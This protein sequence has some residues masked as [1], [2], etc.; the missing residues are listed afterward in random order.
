MRVP[1]SLHARAAVGLLAL[2]AA[3]AA[4]VALP[5]IM[6]D[7]DSSSGPSAE[8][9]RAPAYPEIVVAQ[10]PFGGKL[11][12][13]AFP[14]PQAVAGVPVAVPAS[15]SGA[16]LIADRPSATGPGRP[17]GPSSPVSPT[18]APPS[19]AP[20][21]APAPA[22]TPPSAP[23][24]APS[25]P[26]SPSPSPPPTAPPPASPSP[27]PAPPSTPTPA[28]APVPAPAPA[29]VDPTPP[30]A[31]ESTLAD[32]PHNDVNPGA[33]P[34]PPRPDPTEAPGDPPTD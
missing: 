26:P 8:G 5:A 17:E 31:S 2:G 10:G 1:A 12:L 21:P 14:L 24:P 23:A 3:L 18:P 6:I 4:L 15:S 28:P 20:V 7:D 19:S 25:P 11:P 34:G 29:P 9:K 32:L 33:I 13:P 22:P 30:P 27:P 16:A